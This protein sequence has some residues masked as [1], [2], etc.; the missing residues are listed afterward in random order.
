MCY[1][2]RLNTT[3]RNIIQQR[4]QSKPNTRPEY[5]INVGFMVEIWMSLI[6]AC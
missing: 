2:L 1:M 5:N 3:T 4:L 6:F